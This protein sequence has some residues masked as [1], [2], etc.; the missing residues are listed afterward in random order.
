MIVKAEADKGR[1]ILDAIERAVAES[2]QC[3]DKP[4]PIPSYPT[5]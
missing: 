4:Q 2:Y 3:L 1:Q 5:Q